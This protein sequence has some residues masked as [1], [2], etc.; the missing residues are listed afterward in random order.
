M[1]RFEAAREVIE[2]CRKA[3]GFLASAHLY[4]DFYMRDLVFSEEA[5]LR[6]GHQETVKKQFE[7]FLSRQREDGQIPT[8]VKVLPR[9]ILDHEFHFWTSDTEIL[10]LYGTSRY[11]EHTGDFQFLKENARQLELCRRFVEGRLNRFGFIQGTDWRDAM[12]VYKDRALLAN[13]VLLVAMYDSLGR[14]GEA[15]ALRRKV[16]E[17]FFSR[18]RGFYADFVWREGDELR[19]DFCFDC[20]G[21]SLA[22]LNEVASSSDAYAIATLL[23]SARTR[24]G[25]RNLIPPY[26]INRL[27]ALSSAEG[28]RAFGRTGAFL[29]NRPS[30]YQNSAIW[31]F[32]EARIVQALSKL[33]L[34]RRAEEAFNLMLNRVGFNEWYSPT[35]GEPKGSRMQLWTAASLLEARDSVR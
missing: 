20:F 4:R 2:R 28:L 27:A 25:Y 15:E 26:R 9:F 35:T 5:L 19:R 16:N 22:I 24:F 13:Q 23:E 12:I 11:A 32:V 18:E 31:P 3:D 17:A 14:Q 30:N 1:D 21:N 7:L 8:L 33:G 6:L 10:L 34:E 29:R